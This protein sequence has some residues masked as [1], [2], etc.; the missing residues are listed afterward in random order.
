MTT[1][2][3]V[4]NKGESQETPD[5]LWNKVQADRT[6]QAGEG[7]QTPP[8]G[9]QVQTQEQGQ[10]DPLAAL[11]EPTRE[12]IKGLE[13]RVAAQEEE[14]KRTRQQLAS[15]HGTIG[16]LKQ[17][18]DASQVT[19]QKITPT[20]EAMEAE[21]AARAKKETEEKEKR[22]AE[23]RGRMSD[24]V[25]LTEEELAELLPADAKPAAE[26]KPEPKPADAATPEP[27]KANGESAD[28][29]IRVLT[30]QRELSDRVPG[31]IKTR[32]TPEFKAWRAGPGKSVFEAKA[33]SW[34]P[35]EAAEVFKAFEKHKS[36]AAKVAQV[37]KDRQDRLRRG[38]TPQGRGSS[39]GDVDLSPDAAWNKVKRDRE[40]ARATG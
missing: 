22:R 7:D 17:R 39:T 4:G 15:A 6:A 24:M 18:L 40:K 36:D 5:A 13:T 26:A 2:V 33:G 20:A 11:P 35:D 37:E 23:L 1:E 21:R 8:E 38:E 32:E 12:L 19:L 27:A 25:G 10:A 30:L 3:E 34:D 28:D 29:Q 31:W 9:A 16:N 14:A